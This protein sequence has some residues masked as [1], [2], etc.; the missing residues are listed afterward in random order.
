ML[1]KIVDADHRIAIPGR[2]VEIRLVLKQLVGIVARPF[3]MRDDSRARISPLH[4]AVQQR[5]PL[6]HRARLVEASV[7][8]IKLVP[9]LQFEL[10][11]LLDRGSVNARQPELAQVRLAFRW[12]NDVKGFF[13]ALNAFSYERKQET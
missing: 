5:D 6:G 2:P 4:G 9:V 11:F 13:A 1:R 3:Q 12:I 10:A 7:W 8:E